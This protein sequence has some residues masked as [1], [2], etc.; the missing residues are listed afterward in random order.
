[1]K[2][3]PF[4]GYLQPIELFDVF[5]AGHI[6]HLHCERCGA[7][8]PS[9]YVYGMDRASLDEALSRARRA[10]DKREKDTA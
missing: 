5:D 7:D 10:W 2:P 9:V 4:C 6:A 1:M 8:G 3:C